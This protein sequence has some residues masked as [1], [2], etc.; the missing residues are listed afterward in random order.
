MTS[1]VHFTVD[2]S[3]YVDTTLKLSTAFRDGVQQLDE[4]IDKEL[5]A[6][7]DP[8]ELLLEV[9]AS[10]RM[11]AEEFEPSVQRTKLLAVLDERLRE[12]VGAV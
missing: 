7:R 2:L 1:P 6:G 3:V 12:E 8:K 11:I 4:A 9:Q 10:L 5:Q